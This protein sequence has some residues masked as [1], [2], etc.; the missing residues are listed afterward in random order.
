MGGFWVRSGHLDAIHRKKCLVTRPI[1][2]AAP[3]SQPACCQLGSRLWP[4]PFDGY[5]VPTIQSVPAPGGFEKW[6]STRYKLSTKAKNSRFPEKD[7][8]SS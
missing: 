5:R 8:A 6:P 3:K 1:A 4:I 7:R 2:R